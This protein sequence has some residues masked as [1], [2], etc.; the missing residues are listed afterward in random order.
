M[1]TGECRLWQGA[2]GRGGYGNVVLDGKHMN[3]HR[4]AWILT[5]GPIPAGMCV[6]HTCDVRLCCDPAHLFLGT[7]LDNALD[8]KRKGRTTPPPRGREFTTSGNRPP[9][10]KL[11][12]EQVASVK[13]LLCD[14]V[15]GRAIAAQ[16]GV[17][18]GTI[19]A[20][21]LGKVWTHVAP[22]LPPTQP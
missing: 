16:F 21:K 12:A 15:R 13:A 5:H 20:I 2:V 17:T 4:A 9:A 1:Q 8:A 19:S 22:N 7:P 18:E 14:G 3:T 10:T 6:C 11:T